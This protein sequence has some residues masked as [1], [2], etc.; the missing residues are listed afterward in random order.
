[1]AT[2][3]LTWTANTETDLAGYDVHRALEAAAIGLTEVVIETYA[4]DLRPALDHWLSR[5]QR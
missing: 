5:H 3:T 4:A 1:M 2:A